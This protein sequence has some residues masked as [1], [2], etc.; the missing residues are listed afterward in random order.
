LISDYIDHV[1]AQAKKDRIPNTKGVKSM[2][3]AKKMLESIDADK[4]NEIFT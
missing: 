1:T 4:N 2:K 3:L